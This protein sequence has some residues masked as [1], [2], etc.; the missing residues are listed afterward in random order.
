MNRRTPA[1]RAADSSASVPFVRSSLVPASTSSHVAA[2]LD[3]GEGGR[4][5]HDRLRLCLEHRFAHRRRAEQVEPHRLCA[6]GPQPLG[7]RRAVVGTD[8][9]VPRLDQLRDEP[10][11]DRAARAYEQDSHRIL[12]LDDCGNQFR[13]SC[14]RS[15]SLRAA[16]KPHGVET[17]SRPG[18]ARS[19]SVGKADYVRDSRVATVLSIRPLLVRVETQAVIKNSTPPSSQI[20]PHS[21]A[22]QIA[23]S[24]V[25]FVAR[26][27][28]ATTSVSRIRPRARRLPSRGRA[29]PSVPSEREG[30]TRA[31]AARSRPKASRFRWR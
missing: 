31:K 3:V 25:P 8:H 22:Y 15:Q 9:L 10:S 2:E 4:L 11:A 28:P 23:F 20:G 29:V 24:I 14:M 27:D 30:G 19:R 16:A 21:T 18:L 6:E 7:P 17:R 1:S 5:V 13:F 12:L 26:I